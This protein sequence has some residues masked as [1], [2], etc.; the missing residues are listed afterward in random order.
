[1][2]L[3]PGPRCGLVAVGGCTNGDLAVWA[4]GTA[5][6]PRLMAPTRGQ[7]NTVAV[8]GH[9]TR[10]A[11]GYQDGRVVVYDLRSGE[12]VLAVGVPQ[13]PVNAVAAAPGGGPLVVARG[14][15][16]TVY[17]AGSGEEIHRLAVNRWPVLSVAASEDGRVAVSGGRDGVI[18]VWDLDSG[19]E[20]LALPG[21][22]RSINAL[23]LTHGNGVVAGSSDGHLSCWD[24]DAASEQ[25][26]I[27]TGPWPI[28]A[29]A[30]A[31]A[32]GG[33]R[34]VSGGN[35]G[36]VR[37]WDLQTGE[38]LGPSHRHQEPVNALATAPPSGV[39][40]SG[41]DDRTLRLWNPDQDELACLR[42]PSAVSACTLVEAPV[43][44][45][46]PPA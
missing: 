29:V 18:R 33:H 6:R 44:D 43:P 35:D 39:V 5:V 9:G 10:A 3:S 7:V 1:M 24:L 28:N 32:A 12:R 19:A 31:P 23:A 4:P 2:T 34:L 11:A 30:V 45:T 17:D 14:R 36:A 20:Q 21:G 15:S 22:R 37:I 46:R 13:G 40:L 26:S 38:A 42:T 16:L 8:V 41:S 25:V 27:D